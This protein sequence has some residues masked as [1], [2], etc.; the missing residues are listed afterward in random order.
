MFIYLTVL[1]KKNIL[2]IYKLIKYLNKYYHNNMVFYQTL[3]TW[4]MGKQM[5]RAYFT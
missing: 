3:F 4:F 2:L 5:T 1:L